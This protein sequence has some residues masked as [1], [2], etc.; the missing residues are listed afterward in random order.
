VPELR[1]MGVDSL[2]LDLRRRH[3]DLATLVAKAFREAD[4]ASLPTLKRKCGRSGLGHYR[5]GVF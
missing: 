4:I 3:P 2:G 1:T 5:T